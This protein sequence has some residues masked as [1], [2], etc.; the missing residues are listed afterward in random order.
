MRGCEAQQKGPTPSL[1]LAP[2]PPHRTPRRLRDEPARPP[3]AAPGPW[4]EG[5]RAGQS[6]CLGRAHRPAARAGPWTP[7]EVGLELGT[8]VCGPGALPPWPQK[9]SCEGG[10]PPA[11]RAP[12]RARALSKGLT[13]TLLRKCAGPTTTLRGQP[14]KA[15][16][17]SRRHPPLHRAPT[18]AHAPYQPA[19][20]PTLNAQAP[21]TVAVLGTNCPRATFLQTQSRKQELAESL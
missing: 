18:S 20:P 5:H 8:G 21:A 9:Q 11:D 6:S 1:H 10:T 19:P 4:R 7:G 16:G 15:L 3:G 17:A 12:R 13:A 14:S 2:A